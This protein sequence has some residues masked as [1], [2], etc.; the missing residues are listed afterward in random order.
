MLLCVEELIMVKSHRA[1]SCLGGSGTGTAPGLV[2]RVARAGQ[3]GHLEPGRLLITHPGATPP[4]LPAAAL[5]LSLGVT[6]PKIYRGE[7]NGTGHQDGTGEV[8]QEPEAG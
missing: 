4:P 5:C 3:Q 8:G 7:L 2:S 6:T 1:S